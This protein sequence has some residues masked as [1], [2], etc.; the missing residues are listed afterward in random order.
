VTAGTGLGD[1]VAEP[2]DAPAPTSTVAPVTVA[3]TTTT[4]TVAP[5]PYETVVATVKPDVL[6]LPTFSEPD[7]EP[8][9]F[10]DRL[11]NPTFFGNDLVL[12]V[13]EEAPTTSG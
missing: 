13:I 4:T 12:V 5:D 7:G 6:V 2:T 9:E 1:L 11:T 8:V 3:P 10:A